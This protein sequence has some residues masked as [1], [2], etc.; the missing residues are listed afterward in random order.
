MQNGRA[1]GACLSCD[2]T[3]VLCTLGLKRS[4]ER[5]TFKFARLKNVS[6][7]GQTMPTLEENLRTCMLCLWMLIILGTHSHILAMDW[8]TGSFRLNVQLQFLPLTVRV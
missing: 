1:A 4:R 8:L 5:R 3:T 6:N 7:D 2:S